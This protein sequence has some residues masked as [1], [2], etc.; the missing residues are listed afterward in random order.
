MIFANSI[1]PQNA[2]TALNFAALLINFVLVYL[3]ADFFPPR[4]VK[5]GAVLVQ[6]L[7]TVSDK[8]TVILLAWVGAI[9]VEYLAMI[10]EAIL[11][12]RCP[13]GASSPKCTVNFREF[14]IFVVIE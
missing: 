11:F 9:A 7:F 5:L 12:V 13:E 3:L 10:S 4:S 8:V 14:I 6:R 2:I 1:I